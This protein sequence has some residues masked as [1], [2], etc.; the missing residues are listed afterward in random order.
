MVLSEF[1]EMHPGILGAEMRRPDAIVM[2]AVATPGST[3]GGSH[4]SLLGSAATQWVQ[5]TGSS[6]LL[7]A[8]PRKKVTCALPLWN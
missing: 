6:L 4:H 7:Q 2:L 5:L 8:K 1:P 3:I